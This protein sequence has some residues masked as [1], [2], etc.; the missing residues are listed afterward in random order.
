M[1]A[2]VSREITSVS[3]MDAK[4]SPD[5]LSTTLVRQ[6]VRQSLPMR[7]S[8]EPSLR[9]GSPAGLCRLFRTAALLETRF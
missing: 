2:G 5:L 7:N 6:I 1:T 8:E 4:P 3:L 9:L